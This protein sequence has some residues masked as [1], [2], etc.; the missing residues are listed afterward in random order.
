M[1]QQVNLEIDMTELAH[2]VIDYVRDHDP[3]MIC[4]ISELALEHVDY[5]TLAEKVI[6]ELDYDDMAT[7]VL[8]S[9]DYSRLADYV[10]DD[11]DINDYVSDA[12]RDSD[13][14]TSDGLLSL[15]NQYRIDSSCS[16]A[17]AAQE[18]VEETMDHV[19]DEA[20]I[21]F[22]KKVAGEA[23]YGVTGA[24]LRI[25]NL[26]ET[27]MDAKLSNKAEVEVETQP[28]A[29]VN[30][31]DPSESIAKTV[32]LT[33]DEIVNIFKAIFIY[34]FNA[35]NNGVL[36]WENFIADSIVNAPHLFS[37]E[38]ADKISKFLKGE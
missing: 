14:L 9:I 11:L 29:V 36:S 2:S 25:I 7:S 23:V 34:N 13:A 12:I 35:L 28:Q 31:D 33:S 30:T 16:L 1:K 8:D 17:N 22:D 10:R 3:K 20:G 18:I 26:I 38:S 6:V 21:A 5:D 19:F 4:D 32:E 15:M 27:I 37:G 24:S